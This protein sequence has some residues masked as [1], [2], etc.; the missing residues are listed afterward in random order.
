MNLREIHAYQESQMKQHF[1]E[2]NDC[3]NEEGKLYIFKLFL[4][5]IYF[6]NYFYIFY[7]FYFLK[8]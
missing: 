3:N 1:L 2:L 4:R 6:Y 8:F 5:N 7:C